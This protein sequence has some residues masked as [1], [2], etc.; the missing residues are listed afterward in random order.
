MDEGKAVTAVAHKLSRLMYA[1]LTKG[2]EYSDVGQDYF[3]ERYCGA[4]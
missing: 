3:E 2:E 4:C 1:M